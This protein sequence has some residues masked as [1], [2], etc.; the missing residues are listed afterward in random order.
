MIMMLALTLLAL[1]FALTAATVGRRRWI[2][3]R[4]VS[5]VRAE[6]DAFHAELARQGLSHFSGR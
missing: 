6:L 3:K 2:R 4:G 5:R 1:P